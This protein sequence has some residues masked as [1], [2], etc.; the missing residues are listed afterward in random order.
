M[1][2]LSKKGNSRH[3][4]DMRARVRAEAGGCT[5]GFELDLPA[6]ARPWSRGGLGTTPRSPRLAMDGCGPAPSA[7]GKGR[8]RARGGVTR[9]QPRANAAQS[10]CRLYEWP[11]RP[12]TFSSSCASTGV[13]ALG[14]D[15]RGFLPPGSRCAYNPPTRVPPPSPPRS[16]TSLCERPPFFPPDLPPLAA[17][18]TRPHLS[19]RSNVSKLSGTINTARGGGG[20]SPR[21]TRRRRAPPLARL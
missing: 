10:D 21:L 13:G 7:P 20:V 4:C 11:D 12:S 1:P 18:A 2:A 5:W 3:E 15:S 17:V 6:A 19:I 16:T 8:G 14:G 9:R